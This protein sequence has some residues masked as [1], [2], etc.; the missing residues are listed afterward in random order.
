MT[1]MFDKLHQLATEQHLLVVVDGIHTDELSPQGADWSPLLGGLGRLPDT[2]IVSIAPMAGYLVEITFRRGTERTRSC[3]T[4]AEAQDLVTSLHRQL[5]AATVY[6]GDGRHAAGLEHEFSDR[7]MSVTCWRAC[8]H[9]QA[10]AVTDLDRAQPML[11]ILFLLR[12]HRTPLTCPEP[13]PV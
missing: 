11:E 3:A 13:S 8:A 12:K 5:N 10:V 2:T 6:V 1:W 7:D 9:D 4:S